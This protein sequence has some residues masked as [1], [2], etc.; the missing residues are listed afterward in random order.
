MTSA[1]NL[2]SETPFPLSPSRHLQV[3]MAHYS[4]GKPPSHY[5][6]PLDETLY[7]LDEEESAFFKQETN[8]QDDQVLKQHITAIQAKA[9]AVP[10]LLLLLP[11][12][13]PHLL[14]LRYSLI[15]A[16]AGSRSQSA[17]ADTCPST[18]VLTW[19]PA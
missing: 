5:F 3:K 2:F 9:F 11:G 13:S 12:G 4:G 14:A 6:L 16:F 8:I 17:R 7:Q 15:H 19:C 1:D 18:I 10:L